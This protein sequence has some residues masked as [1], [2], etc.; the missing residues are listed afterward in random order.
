MDLSPED[1]TIL[2]KVSLLKLPPKPTPD[3]K[4]I[5]QR[6]LKAMLKKADEWMRA[7]ILTAL[8]CAYGATNCSRLQWSMIDFKQGVIRF[9]RTKAIGRIKG[10]VPRIAVLWQRTKT[11]L[12]K[13]KNDHAHVFVSTYGRPVHVETIRRHWNDLC[14]TAGIKRDLAFGILRKSAQTAAASSKNPVVPYQQYRVLAGHAFKGVDDN[15]IRRNP[16][17]VELACKAIERYYFPR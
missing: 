14:K 4:E 13:A 15:Y 11:A 7:L 1:Q 3:P 6:E 16:R 12:R 10:A 9:D 5:T 2:K 17:L 8:N